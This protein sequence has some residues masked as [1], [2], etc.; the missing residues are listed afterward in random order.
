M[1][2]AV[3]V[4]IKIG[5]DGDLIRLGDFTPLLDVVSG[6]AAMTGQP[7]PAHD[8]AHDHAHEVPPTAEFGSLIQDDE[9]DRYEPSSKGWAASETDIEPTDLDARIDQLHGPGAAA[10]IDEAYANG[11]FEETEQ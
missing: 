5:D 11:M 7:S 6:L 4:Y 1:P 8:H 9:A 2:E 10:A 3:P